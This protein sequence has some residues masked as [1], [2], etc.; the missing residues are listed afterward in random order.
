[1]RDVEKAMGQSNSRNRCEAIMNS[2]R[3]DRKLRWLISLLVVFS[4]MGCWGEAWAAITVSASNTSCNATLDIE[5]SGLGTVTLERQEDTGHGKAFYLVADGIQN[6]VPIAQ[7]GLFS[8]SITLTSTSRQLFCT[9]S[10]DTTAPGTNVF[11]YG[12]SGKLFTDSLY[13]GC[14]GKGPSAT[15]QFT[16]GGLGGATSFA[17][18]STDATGVIEV[19]VR[20]ADGFQEYS[21]YQERLG[22]AGDNPFTDF[23]T[24]GTTIC[25][26]QGLPTAAVNTAYLNLVV[27]DS[28]L[29]YRSF[30]HELALRRVWNMTSGFTG[31]FG[32]GWSFAYGAS[33]LA[34]DYASGGVSLQ[35][36]TG[37]TT[38]YAVAD[39]QGTG[40]VTVNYACLS[41]GPQPILTGTINESTR[42][43]SYLLY[44]KQAKLTSRFE[45]ARDD[46]MG[47]HVYRLASITDRNGNALVLTYD[48]SG[49]LSSLADASNRTMT[50]NYDAS[51][52]CT[53]I[54]TPGSLSAAFVYDTSG[55]LTRTTDLAGN[56]S[57][58]AYDSANRITSMTAAGKTTSFTYG[59]HNGVVHVASVTDA[60]GKVWNYAFVTGGTRVTEPGGGARTYASSSGQTTSA[61]DELGQTSTT[62]YN[63]LGLPETI[64]DARGKVTT[65]AYDS[66]GNL[67]QVTDAK[68]GVTNF[69]YDVN[70]NR[71]TTTDALGKIWSVSYDAKNNPDSTTT[72]LGSTMTLAYDAKGQLTTLIKPGGGVYSFSHDANG[73]LT[74]FTNPLHK[75]TTFTYDAAG[76]NLASRTD[77]RGK[78]TTYQFD[79]NRRLTRLAPP[80]GGPTDF[81]YDCCALSSVTDGNG[82]AT[83]YSRDAMLHILRR[84]DPLGKHYD[85]IYDDRGFLSSLTDPLGRPSV[86]TRDAASRI[87]AVTDPRG[88][89][90]SRGLDALGQPTTVTNERGKIFF[91]GYD[92]LGLLTSFVDPLGYPTASVV[93]DALGR[94]FSTTGAR[95]LA[96]SYLR[97]DDGRVIGKRHDATVVASY[98]YDSD[99]LPSSVTDATGTTSFTRDAADQI[100]GMTYPDGT[101]LGLGYDDAGNIS[102]MTYPGGLVVNFAYDGRN[103]PTSVSF[104]GNTLNLAYDNAGNLSSE[105]RSNGVASVYVHDAANRLTGLS[106]KKGASVVADLVYTRDAAGQITGE[107]G[108]WPLAPRLASQNVAA[109]YNDAD[110][111]TTWGTDT[112]TYDADGNL[113]AIAGTRALSATYD[114]EN[115]PTSLILGGKT[116]MYAYDGLGNRVRVQVGSSVR[117]IHYDPLGRVVFET[118]ASGQITANYIYAGD[119]LV[120]SGTTAGGFVFHHQDKTG[121]TLA[122]TDDTGAVVGKY[123]YGPFGAVSNRVGTVVTPFTYVGANGVMDDSDG[124]FFMKNRYYDAIAGRFLQRDPIGFAGGVNLYRYVGNNPVSRIDPLGLDDIADGT[125]DINNNRLPVYTQE[126]LSGEGMFPFDGDPLRQMANT[127]KDLDNWWFGH[128]GFKRFWKVL[129]T[130]SDFTIQNADIIAGAKDSYTEHPRGYYKL[131]SCNKAKETP[132]KLQE[133]LERI[134]KRK[135]SSN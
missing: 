84:T 98:A 47:R 33:L 109:T 77:P 101:T 130:G 76:L 29:R 20:L 122:L 100:T 111:I 108:T 15:R 28:D 11:W 2:R 81:G 85:Y 96:T 21:N 132:S 83:L 114:P 52:R 19:Y 135:V 87:T 112:C 36:G 78:I 55:N 127:I 51:N 66:N 10:P 94:I 68:G 34:M 92:D 93:R 107:A 26:L 67:M 57:T 62:T 128:G 80:D 119:R 63:A 124:L 123:A 54:Q 69:A 37:Q 30:G 102:T 89:I 44:D 22:G 24:A 115:R 105:T 38:A 65:L 58:Y 46:G 17:Y 27:E 48:G 113:T 25:P 97:D 60:L 59:T 82:H 79:A 117:N 120:A 13:L 16:Y 39:S 6:G 3:T 9:F 1:M 14:A 41:P 118:N 95:G 71:T 5:V 103:L 42:V 121:N 56:I 90:V 31:M 116:R 88:K 91:L 104:G 134:K 61:V 75:Q 70:W 18:F 45:Y 4:W 35:S 72:P 131:E 50:F 126:G 49:R 32:N 64:T 23:D 125:Y 43:G 133:L 53:L 129:I 86:I 99:G 8:I 110:G 74:G 12:P 7:A 73:N 106:H 40:T